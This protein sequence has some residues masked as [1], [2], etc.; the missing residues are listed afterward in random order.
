M[1]KNVASFLTKLDKLSE[2][3]IEVFVPSLKK[4]IPTKPLNL[5]QQ[6]DLISSMLDGI[7]GTLDF[8]KTL[9]RIIIDNTG[10]T[11]L[12][13]YDKLPFIVSMR[14]H[15]LGN[16]AGSVELQSVID[17]IKNIPFNIK[18]TTTV[19]KG[20]I[21]LVLTVPTL[22]QENILLTK[23]EQE[24]DQDQELAKDGVGKLYIYEIIKYI[25]SIQI[26]DDV[27]EM[28]DIRINERI[29][30]VERLP[31]TMYSKI[32]DFIESVN[33]YNSDVLTVDET[34]VSIDSEFFDTSADD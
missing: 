5:K 2:K 24:I 14:K 27:L 17:N 3:T 13:I 21:Q 20:G 18:D 19:K 10:I 31:L 28:D 1:S 16:R 6:K 9:N 23:C 8:S 33:R 4:K 32:S 26:D 12:K 15:A 25:D 30:L 22:R 34:E 29:K 11:D 7:K